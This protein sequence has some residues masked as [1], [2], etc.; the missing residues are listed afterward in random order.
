MHVKI[1]QGL[2][3]VFVL[4]M[5]AFLLAGCARQATVL[6]PAPYSAAKFQRESGVSPQEQR[7]IDK[8]CFEGEPKLDQNWRFGST[9]LVARDGYVLRHSAVDKIPLW[10]CE[11]VDRAQLGGNVARDD[12]F[13][14]DP[15]LKPG[16]RAEL[17]DYRRSGYDR[18]HMA[19]AANQSR[20]AQLK[21]ET[22]YLSNMAP[23][24][25]ALNQQ[26]WRELEDRTRD[27]LDARGAGY[28][29]T[30]PMF[31]DPAEENEATADGVVTGK[32][33][34]PNK[35]AVPTH[36]YKIVVAKD[37]S[38][39]WQ[40]IAFVMENRSYRR[41]FRFEEHITSIDWIEKRTGLDFMPE[42]DVLEQRRL[43]SAVSP[44]WN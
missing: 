19:P 1:H 4:G 2:G 22:F 42:M 33:I 9:D 3:R 13:Q 27:W 38:G 24:K 29:I 23:Q 5:M 32:A 37:G 34:G 36:F 18:G 39:E 43:E 7:C 25:G 20:D 16:R 12:A 35:V 26:I 10:V 41:P 28:V 6:R 30:G 11:Y 14:P 15:V 40:S 21:R 17:V 8:H 44:L 31:Y